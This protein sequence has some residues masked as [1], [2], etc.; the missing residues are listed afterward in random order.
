MAISVSLLTN[1]G[2]DTDAADYT[3]ASVSP[4]AG[5]LV[6]AAVHVYDAGASVSGVPTC[7]G[8]GLT[9]TRISSEGSTSNR[10]TAFRA[11]A[12]PGL[13]TSGAVTFSGVVSSGTADGAQWIV[14]EVSGINTGAA[15]NA[16]V[17]AAGTTTVN[18]SINVNLSAFANTANGTIGVVSAYD[19]AGG[20]LDIT[21]G[22]GF[23]PSGELSTTAGGDTLRMVVEWK[24]TNDTGVNATVSAA[25][26]RM[27]IIGMEI[28]GTPSDFLYPKTVAL[29]AA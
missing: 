16:V 29:L 28:D 21:E 4:T 19:S 3:T 9:W 5:R 22:S 20:V 26:D 1:N 24:T 15:N 10:L 17:Q 13:V 8:C 23:S 7:S 14:V 6:L 18:D 12:D 2:S 27:C 11:Y 25:N